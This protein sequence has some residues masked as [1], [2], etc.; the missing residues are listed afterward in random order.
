MTEVEAHPVR[1]EYV[2]ERRLADGRWIAVSPDPAP[3]AE[4]AL[5]DAWFMEGSTGT[6]RTVRRTI[7]SVVVTEHPAAAT[8]DPGSPR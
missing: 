5:I 4:E 2:V 7:A 3:T 8:S 1:Y 6:Y